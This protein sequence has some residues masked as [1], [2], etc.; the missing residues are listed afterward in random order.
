MAPTMDYD[1]TTSA[2]TG[3]RSSSELRRLILIPILHQ[4][5]FSNFDKISDFISENSDNRFTNRPLTT[6]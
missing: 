3:Q 1:T 4:N 5:K 6:E 2:L